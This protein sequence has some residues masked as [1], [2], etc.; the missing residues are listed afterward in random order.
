MRISVIQSNSINSFTRSQNNSSAS[1]NNVAFGYGITM[2]MRTFNTAEKC[3]KNPDKLNRLR[4]LREFLRGQQSDYDAIFERENAQLFPRVERRMQEL[5]ESSIEKRRKFVESLDEAQR[6]TFE[7]IEEQKRALLN[8]DHNNSQSTLPVPLTSPG[9]GNRKLVTNLQ[10]DI[11]KR[12]IQEEEV[13][14]RQLSSVQ[15]PLYDD[16]FGDLLKLSEFK[17]VRKL[18]NLGKIKDTGF[19]EYPSV[20]VG[21]KVLKNGIPAIQVRKIFD[22]IDRAFNWVSSEQDAPIIITDL[23]DGDNKLKPDAQYRITEAVTETVKR[24]TEYIYATVS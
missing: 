11:L 10:S 15:R 17:K 23:F 16:Y 14:K 19:N 1:K 9:N 12:V 7:G 3:L 18:A 13:F 24:I 2:E 4:V 8:P 22:R 5:I 21:F 20:G 6:E